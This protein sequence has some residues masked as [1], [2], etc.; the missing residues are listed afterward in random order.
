MRAYI[1]SI[2]SELIHGALTDT[3]ATFLAQEAIAQ[4]IELLHVVQI[5]DDLERLTRS[6]EL[7]VSDADLVICTGGIGPTDDDLTR[8]AISALADETPEVEAGLLETVRAFFGQRGLEMPERNAKQAWLIPSAEPLPNPVGTAPG[9]FVRIDGKVVVAMP[10]VPRE[11]YRMWREQALP[12]LAP[13]LPLRAYR[14]ANLRT[15]GIGESAVAER[16]GD[17]TKATNPYVGTYAKDDGV[18]VRITASG[19]TDD[20]AASLLRDALVEI[21]ER[22]ATTV[23]TEDERSLAAVLLDHLRVTG[24][25]LG[26]IESGSGGQFAGLLLGEPDAG[27]VVLGAAAL[28]RGASN[29][30]DLAADARTRFGTDLGFGIAVDATPAAQGLFEGVVRFALAGRIERIEEIPLRATWAEIQRRAAM[31][32]ADLLRRAVLGHDDPVVESATIRG[33]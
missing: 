2:G 20:A 11:M 9:W 22:L 3:N 8:E 6:L 32:A 28:P 25:T 15:L 21:R 17:L 7:A 1:L 26:I 10:G 31:H 24:L 29:A 19:A 30:A 5:G 4:G 14:S 23:Y 13:M 18:H 16:L 33:N 12:R 27:D